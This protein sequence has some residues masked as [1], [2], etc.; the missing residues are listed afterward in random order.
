MRRG[1][2]GAGDSEQAAGSKLNSNN[3]TDIITVFSLL[4]YSSMH[5]NIYFF[6]SHKKR[7]LSNNVC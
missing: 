7:T 5:R 2:A 4:V 1:V 6:L 3:Q